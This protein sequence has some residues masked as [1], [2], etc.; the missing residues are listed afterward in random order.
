[1]RPVARETPE[2]SGKALARAK[3]ALAARKAPLA[4]DRAAA[5]AELDALIERTAGAAGA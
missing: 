5:R 3:R 4:F 1:M 2:L